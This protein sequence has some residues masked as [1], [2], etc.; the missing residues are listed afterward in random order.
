[1]P[2]NPNAFMPSAYNTAAYTTTYN[3]IK[4]ILV[5]YL[6]IKIT[7]KNDIFALNHY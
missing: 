5:N 1:M 2:S 3:G 4:D 6:L 7:A